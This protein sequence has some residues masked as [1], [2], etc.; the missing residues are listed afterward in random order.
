MFPNTFW[1]LWYYIRYQSSEGPP[2]P[3]IDPKWDSWLERALQFHRNDFFIRDGPFPSP[4]FHSV[5]CRWNSCM[6]SVER[7]CTTLVGPRS[8]QD[9]SIAKVEV[10]RIRLKDRILFILFRKMHGVI[11]LPS[12]F[13]FV[14]DRPCETR[15]S[16]QRNAWTGHWNYLAL[17]V[18]WS[19]NLVSQ[20]F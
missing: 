18:S 4:S 1:S 7:S 10:L 20:D 12:V 16:W 14:C 8:R 11:R 13:Y 5:F 3:C 15:A 6:V 19:L 17:S 9:I 2:A